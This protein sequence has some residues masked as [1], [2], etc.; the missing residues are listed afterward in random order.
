MERVEAKFVEFRQMACEA[1]FTDQNTPTP[2]PDPISAF[3][4][5]EAES[6]KNQQ[7]IQ[8]ET[9]TEGGENVG[10]IENG[11]YVS[12]SNIDFGNGA[13][14]FQ[15]RVAS[16]TSGGNIEIRLDSINGTLIGT[17]PLQEQVAGRT[18]SM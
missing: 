8:T 15:A 7:G 1:G 3:T 11:D 9:C 10:Y 13:A 16:A 18:G 4:Q 6:F 17:C 5:I 12:Y 2:T 14:G